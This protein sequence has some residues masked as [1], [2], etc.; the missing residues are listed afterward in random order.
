MYKQPP[1]TD[2]QE[3][4]QKNTQASPEGYSSEDFDE[5]RDVEPSRALSAPTERGIYE[6]NKRDL[7]GPK[8][9][10]V[11]KGKTT[12]RKHTKAK[13]QTVECKTTNFRILTK[14]IILFF[15]LKTF[16]L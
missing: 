10:K 8:P 15:E 7:S 1:M 14:K 9:E 3:N 5:P 6:E 4:T 2:T 11:P 12:G 16:I 13:W